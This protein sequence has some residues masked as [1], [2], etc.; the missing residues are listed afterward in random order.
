MKDRD[1]FQDSA[2]ILITKWSKPQAIQHI[3]ILN[4]KIFSLLLSK[5][6]GVK[7][8]LWKVRCIKSWVNGNQ[9][10]QAN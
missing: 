7:I 2:V 3:S 9:V 6:Y 8:N 10:T 4:L 5:K 1:V